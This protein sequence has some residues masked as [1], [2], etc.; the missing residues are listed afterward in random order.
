MPPVEVLELDGTDGW[1]L[2]RA[3]RLAALADAPDAF[4][5]ASAEWPNGGEAR[6]RARLFD[7]TALKVVAV[8][9]EVPVGLVRGAL[10]DGCAWLHS[11]WVSP[12]VRARDLAAD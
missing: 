6:W 9:D 10:E 11:L 4:T 5:G 7:T 1:A 12:Q 3:A 2:W 8:R